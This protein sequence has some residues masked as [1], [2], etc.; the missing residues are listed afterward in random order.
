MGAPTTP[1]LSSTLDSSS[2]P[3]PVKLN[4]QEIAVKEITFKAAN[5][6][7]RRAFIPVMAFYCVFCFVGPALMRAFDGSTWLK[8]IV[9]ILSGAPIAVVFW[10]MGRYLRETDEFT[11]KIQLEALVPGAGITL[12][13]AMVWGFLELYRVVPRFEVFSPMMMVGPAFFF[14]GVTFTAQRLLRG[15]SLCDAPAI[16]RDER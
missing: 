9:S 11:R 1:L 14:Y 12:S 3:A 2:L 5:R 10:L 16:G 13:L 15:E 8:A 7:Y 6:R 4:L